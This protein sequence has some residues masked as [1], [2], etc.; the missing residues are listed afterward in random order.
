MSS[1]RERLADSRFACGSRERACF[2]AGIKMGTIYHQFV[3]TPFCERNVAE[4]EAAIADCI[5]VQ[6]YVRD[7]RV[8]I[9]HGD[10]NKED[11]Y[12]Y[13][14]LTGD[15]IDATVVV[16]VGGTAVR[17]VMRYDDELGYPLMYIEDIQ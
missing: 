12:S 17:A 9:R 2:E 15:M 7:A 13:S 5:K 1:D 6:P 16:E 3:G 8:S 14:S 10:G 4:L 11:Q